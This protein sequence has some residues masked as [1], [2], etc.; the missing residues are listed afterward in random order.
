[1]LAWG[2]KLPPED[3]IFE[4]LESRFVWTAWKP[5]WPSLYYESQIDKCGV[6]TSLG[7]LLL[8]AVTNL[9][10]LSSYRLKAKMTQL[11]VENQLD[12]RGEVECHYR[13]NG[14]GGCWK[15]WEFNTHDACFFPT[16]QTYPLKIFFPL[17]AEPMHPRLGWVLCSMLGGFTVWSV[18]PL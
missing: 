7:S 15:C 17:Q 18:F 5:T 4:G 12:Q 14:G 9:F 11:Q 2:T 13:K 1:M 3:N 8:P 6:I 16:W 10:E